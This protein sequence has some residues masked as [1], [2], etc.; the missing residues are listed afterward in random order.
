MYAKKSPTRLWLRET[1]DVELHPNGIAPKL[2]CTHLLKKLLIL[3][4]WIKLTFCLKFSLLYL[5]YSL[6]G[7][8]R[9]KTRPQRS[10]IKLWTPGVYNKQGRK[11]PYICIKCNKRGTFGERKERERKRFGILYTGYLLSIVKIKRE[12]ERERKREKKREREEKEKK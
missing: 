6:G 2:K 9:N 12:K 11:H 10:R 4:V 1:L 7:Y 5:I 8:N 3:F